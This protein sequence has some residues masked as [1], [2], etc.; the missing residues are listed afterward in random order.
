M[1][2]PLKTRK[3]DDITQWYNEVLVAS[4]AMDF[5]GVKGF[6]VYRPYGYFMW[7]VMQKALDEEIK[8]R[9]VKNAYFPLLIPESTLS[10]EKEHIK[11]F[12]PEVAWV[13]LGG[14]K[15]LEEKLAIRPTSE[16]IMYESYSKWIK[17]YRDLPILINQWN[18]V[19]RWETKETRL[20]LRGREVLWQEGHCAFETEK[21]AESNAREMG[22]VY[23]KIMEEVL[24]V[25]VLFGKK[26]ESEKFAGAVSTYTVEAILP[27]NFMSQAGTSHYLGENFARPFDIKYLDRDNKWRFVQQTS[28]GMAMR[29][30]GIMIM[31]YGDDKG[32][33]LPPAVA[34]IQVV[35]IPIIKGGDSE[36]LLGY[37]KKVEKLLV[38]EGIRVLLD[39]RIEY[40][41]GWK[42]NEYDLK[43]V[44]IKL[45]IGE[46]EL[47]SGSVTLKF[48]WSG[49]KKT[50]KLNSLQ[51]LKDVLKSIQKDMLEASKKASEDRIVQIKDREGF[52]SALKGEKN[53]AK[54]AWCGRI[55]CEEEIKQ[56]TGATSRLILLDKEKLIS[57]VCVFCGRKAEN[58]AVFAKSY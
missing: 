56:A 14:E 48:R 51:S 18:N 38:G 53:V 21:E 47:A 7:E 32:L 6:P 35:I 9:N 25:P 3:R 39:D 11:G 13:T 42:F 27:N 23:K 31:V 17:S 15:Q 33:V 54:A 52:V 50:I 46:R 49:A 16:T 40:S 2:E 37:V 58:N 1:V 10:K 41:P 43:G 5:S 36:K 34:P 30:L 55:E 24:A 45:E 20:L 28:W 19:V 57:D 26:S 44:P 8:K 29:A 12:N 4:E 22:L